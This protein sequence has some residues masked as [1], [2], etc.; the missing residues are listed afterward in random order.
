MC[1]NI[2]YNFFYVE[3]LAYVKLLP[4]ASLKAFGTKTL[5]NA[6]R[7]CKPRSDVS[8]Y[9][10]ASSIIDK[11]N[12]YKCIMQLG[13]KT[14]E[15]LRPPR[16]THHIREALLYVQPNKLYLLVTART[17]LSRLIQAHT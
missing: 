11:A 8:A 9:I 5:R 17:M 16:C 2:F 1:T 10:T 12:E 15:A 4:L 3:R 13:F 7:F 14:H 6:S